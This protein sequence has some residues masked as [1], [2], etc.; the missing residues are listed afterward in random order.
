MLAGACAAVLTG[1]FPVS[2]LS[3]RSSEM[4]RQMWGTSGI[5]LPPVY[6]ERPA[7][8]LIRDDHRSSIIT[9]APCVGVVITRA[10]WCLERTLRFVGVWSARAFTA[11]HVAHSA[12]LAEWSLYGRPRIREEKTTTAHVATYCRINGWNM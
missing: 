4:V 8:D 1:N 5:G 11:T 2:L 6:P 7:I 10:L 3:F 9:G 12:V